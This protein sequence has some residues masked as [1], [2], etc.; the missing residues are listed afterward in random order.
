MTKSTNIR[1]WSR[2]RAVT[3]VGALA[4]VASVAGFAGGRAVAPV[5]AE[6][7]AAAVQ[8]QP[9]RSVDRRRRIAVLSK[10]S[11]RLW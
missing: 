10:E 3:T 5:S 11:R 1:G 4:I 8:N 6:V 9:A 2:S 7:S